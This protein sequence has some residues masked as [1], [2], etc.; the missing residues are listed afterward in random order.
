MPTSSISSPPIF[1]TMFVIG[2]TEV[3]TLNFVG[4]TFIQN[5]S[6]NF[7]SGCYLI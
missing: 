4:E 2:E 6:R 1:L 7:L 5:F 3:T